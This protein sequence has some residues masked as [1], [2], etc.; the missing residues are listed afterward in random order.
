MTTYSIEGRATC[1]SHAEA[2]VHARSRGAWL[3]LVDSHDCQTATYYPPQLSMGV[4]GH[5]GDKATTF[6]PFDEHQRPCLWPT[7]AEAF[8]AE[9]AAAKAELLRLAAALWGRASTEGLSVNIAA[10]KEGR[11]GGWRCTASDGLYAA[12]GGGVGADH[13]A[14]ALASIESVRENMRHTRGEFARA[15]GETEGRLANYHARVAAIDAA[16]AA[17]APRPPEP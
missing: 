16:L 8:E 13:L 15:I 10:N 2:A 12:C 7:G 3:V 14:A 9:L 4:L 17:E 11:L 6:Y 1:P 5:A